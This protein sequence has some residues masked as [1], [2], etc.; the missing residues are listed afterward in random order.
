MAFDAFLKIGEIRG[1]STDA[2]HKDWI[3]LESYALGLERPV[4]ASGSG[5]ASG[6]TEFSEFTFV[7]RDARAALP[8]LDSGVR[9]LRQPAEVHLATEDLKT[10]GSRV[11]ASYKL[12][13]CVVTS[14][15]EAGSPSEGL[16]AQ[17]VTL[18]YQKAELSNLREGTSAVFDNTGGTK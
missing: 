13:D 7:A 18:R 3:A 14:V 15:R 8:V 1:S 12:T 4:A 2:A 5:Q 9:G 17:A 16:P 10:G 6:K 11:Y